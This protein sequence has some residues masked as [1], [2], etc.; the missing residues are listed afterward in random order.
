M[1]MPFSFVD[2]I[3]GF[4]VNVNIRHDNF[5][6]FGLYLYRPNIKKD[7]LLKY[8][9]RYNASVCKILDIFADRIPFNIKIKILDLKNKQQY[10]I[11]YSDLIF[12]VNYLLKNR[13]C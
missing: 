3:I 12:D 10:V 4:Q 7:D 1:P 6:F 5:T 13:I 8:R 2:S 11:N 9:G